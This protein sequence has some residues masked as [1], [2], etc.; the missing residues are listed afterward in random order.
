MELRRLGD[1]GMQVSVICLGTMTW[2][3]QNTADQAFEQ[4]DYALER[5]VNFFDT[6]EMYAVPANEKT[7]GRTEEIIGEW[8]V[9]RKCR[10]KIVLAT[11]VAGPSDLPWLRGGAR[12]SLDAG[13][14]RKAVEGSLRRLQTDYIDLYQVHWPQRKT[15]Y[16]GTVRYK[17]PDA[18]PEVTIEETLGALADLVKEGKIRAVGVSNETPWGMLEYFRLHREKGLPRVASVQNPY[19]LLRREYEIGMAEISYRERCGLLAYSPLA[20][21]ALSGK[22]LD[23]ARPEGARMTLWGDSFGRY[24]SGKHAAATRSYVELARERGYDPAQMAI[25]FTVMQPFLTSSI[26]GATTMEQLRS[27]IGSESVK[28]DED[29]VKRIEEIAD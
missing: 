6:A 4:M 27:D 14:V 18:E 20:F 15:N 1:T 21:G 8:F 16:F 2:G 22:Y 28:L 26:I 3:E 7:A 12:T 19:S 24:L 29:T 9:A 10:D 11:K 17:V 5:G 25:A 23:G 13:Q